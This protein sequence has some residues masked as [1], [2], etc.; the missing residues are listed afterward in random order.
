MREAVASVVVRGDAAGSAVHR[1]RPAGPL[2]L[3]CP[4][5]PGGAAWIVAGNLGGG[6]VD[7]DDLALEVS[8][9]RGA[10]CVVT[11][12][13]STKVYRGRTR[14]RT[15]VRVDEDATA[16]VAPDPV[17]PFRGA[18]LVQATSIELAAGASLV[19]VDTLTA[20][21]V[22]YGERWSA[23]R[24]DS[25]LEVAIAG[26]PRL[27]DRVVLDGDAGAR[28]QRFAALATCVVVGP[29]AAVAAARA[30]AQL[31]RPAPRAPVVVAGS[32]LAGG[33]VFRIAGERV[34][35]VTGAV[36]ALV[37]EACAELGAIPWQRR[38]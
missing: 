20:G 29:R 17:V 10:T 1:A 21:R 16:I 14:Q 26:E 15:M 31:T 5:R 18:E 7:G 3:L 9:G 35:L 30:L 33:A 11:T 24:I 25:A 2:R 38:W 13:A 37:G 6:L 34:D 22:A 36:R 4:R 23:A 27:I 32:P 8:V 19:L 12:Q 28:M